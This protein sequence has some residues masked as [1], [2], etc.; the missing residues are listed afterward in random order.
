MIG[1]AWKRTNAQLMAVTTRWLPFADAA[2]EGLPLSQLLRLSLF[3]VSVGMATVLLLGTLNRVMI[4]ELS[5]PAV[6]VA[7]MI[8]LPVLIAPFRALLGFRSDTYR[9]A[10]GWKRIPYLWFGSLWQ[11]GGL[12]V[13]PFALLVLSGQQQVGPDMGGRGAGRHRLFDD[14]PRAA[15]DADR[16]VWRSPRIAP[17]MRPAPASWR[18]ST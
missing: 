1:Q 16:R 3:Q 5:V 6:I 4:V 11:M 15:H 10:L 8:A 18:C 14:R 9:S 12:A 17:P 2:S 7:V 13:M